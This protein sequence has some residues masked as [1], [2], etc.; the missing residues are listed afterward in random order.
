MWPFKKKMNKFEG[1]DCGITLSGN[2]NTQHKTCAVCGRV[3]HV[4]DMVLVWFDHLPR[5]LV[6]CEAGAYVCK[7]CIGASS[8]D[9]RKS[10]ND[11]RKPAK[12]R[13]KK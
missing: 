10:N 9:R 13:G 1:V 5:C 3:N 11:R 2:D 12:K 4:A 6:T 7:H 8:Y